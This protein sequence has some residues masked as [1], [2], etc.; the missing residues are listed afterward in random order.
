MEIP[1]NL[2]KEVIQLFLDMDRTYDQVAGKTGFE[3]RGCDDN[4]CRTR[5]HHHTL[6]ELLYLKSGLAALPHAL[7]RR[8]KDQAHEV[9]RQEAAGARG[10]DLIRVMC[11]L[12]EHGRCVLYAHRPM[13]CRLHGIPHGLRRPDG[14]MVSGPGCDDF[15]V[16]C[17]NSDR[18]HLDR[19]P[20][21]TVMACL[22]G[23]L[24]DQLGVNQKIKMTVAEM[25]IN[26]IYRCG[27]TR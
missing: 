24:R 19:T 14:R 27:K 16:Q 13:I 8:I 5:F 20:V 15:Y 11:P 4:C 25:I 21:Y 26:E 2:E 17:K 18:A 3:C 6:I 23:R 9:C 22:E 10:S 12:N 1:A 7:Q